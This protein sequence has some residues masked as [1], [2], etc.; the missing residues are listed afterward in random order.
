[1]A[2]KTYRLAKPSI[3]KRVWKVWLYNLFWSLL[4]FSIFNAL[5]TIDDVCYHVDVFLMYLRPTKDFVLSGILFWFCFRQFFKDANLIRYTYLMIKH[6]EDIIENGGSKRMYEGAEGTGKTLNTANEA[7]FLA[8][9]KDRDMR[10]RYYLSVPFREELKDDKDFKVLEESFNF[11][12]NHLENIPHL[13]ANFKIKYEGREQYD[14][15]MQYF[16]KE[17]RP[18]EGLSVALTEVGNLLPNSW[19]KMP[20]DAENDPYKR[21][22]KSEMFSLSRQYLDM[23]VVSDEQ[24]TGEVFL[25]FRSLSSRN[26][27]LV[28]R[29][30]VLKPTFLMFILRR[31]ENKILKKGEK[32]TQKRSKRYRKLEDVI[33]DIGF[34]LFVMEDREA[35]DG[36]VK[37]EKVISVISCD[38][39]FEFDTRG[40]RYKYTL[41]SHT[42]EY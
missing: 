15:N 2:K 21:A 34:Y 36:H 23:H 13:M 25:G 38:L 9:K 11:Y 19:S 37:R 17:K 6:D 4:F 5:Y 27:R 35:Q 3:V 24:R 14:F 41:Y 42:P 16:D 7:L 29:I 18:P 28:E 22:I 10:L 20:A 40:E 12:E 30:K 33:Q 8:A 31:I 1:M 39:P 26:F 32:N